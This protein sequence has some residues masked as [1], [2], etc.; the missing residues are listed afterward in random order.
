MAYKQKHPYSRNAVSERERFYRRELLE[1]KAKL[2][3][4]GIPTWPVFL[5]EKDKRAFYEDVER[6]AER[7]GLSKDA[8]C[9]MRNERKRR[10]K[11]W[12]STF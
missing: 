1:I 6:A 11:Q 7:N 5:S 8:V 12:D 10:E 9:A 3:S 2:D 4:A